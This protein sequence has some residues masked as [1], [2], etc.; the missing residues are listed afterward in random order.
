MTR[1]TEIKNSLTIAR[2]EGGGNSGEKGFQE[3]LQ[4]THGQNQGAG[5]GNKGGRWV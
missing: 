3:Q 1:D 5:V 4:R 2:G